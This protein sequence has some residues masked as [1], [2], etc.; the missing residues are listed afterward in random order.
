MEEASK[1]WD[2]ATLSRILHDVK[3]TKQASFDP[4]TSSASHAV[5]Q[6]L[7]AGRPTSA[8]ARPASARTRPTSGTAHARHSAVSRSATSAGWVPAASTRNLALAPSAW[9][10]D[11]AAGLTDRRERFAE[12][13]M[14]GRARLQH[15]PP[16][17]ARAEGFERLLDDSPIRQ[18]EQ[19]EAASP[20]KQSRILHRPRR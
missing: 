9:T 19:A 11:D 1:F 6:V 3:L 7:G 5:Q 10:D 14:T 8:S 20:A 13:P 4:R 15:T 18:H 12:R 16:K 2:D 17:S